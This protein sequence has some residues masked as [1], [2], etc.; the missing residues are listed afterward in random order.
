MH[1]KKGLVFDNQKYFSKL[2]K[3]NFKEQISFDACKNFR[4]FDKIL[5]NYSVIIFVIYSEDEIFEF[6]KAYN[7]GVP[8][9]L[10]TF[11]KEILL[12]LRR[13]DDIM[14]V[15]SSKILPEIVTELRSYFSLKNLL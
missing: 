6:I 14:L 13:I 7:L 8:L 15:D 11:N 2:I 4:Y 12:K 1:K 9:I 10:C 3:K 5:N